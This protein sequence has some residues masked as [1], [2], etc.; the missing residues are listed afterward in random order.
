MH[1]LGR[2]ENVLIHR[3]L[4]HQAGILVHHAD[5]QLMPGG[6]RGDFYLLAFNKNFT[7]VPAIFPG[8]NLHQGRFAGPVFTDDTDN[9]SSIKIYRDIV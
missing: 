2:Q 1:H 6:R 4:R 8:Q 7:A 5:A 3:Q 9:L